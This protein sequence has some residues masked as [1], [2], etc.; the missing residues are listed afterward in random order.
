M[1]RGQSGSSLHHLSALF[2]R[3]KYVFLLLDAMIMTR[4][5]YKSWGARLTTEECP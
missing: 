3:G 2:P 5:A 4:F 1:M